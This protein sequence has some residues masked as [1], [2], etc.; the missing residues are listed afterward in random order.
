MP[1]AI[2]TAIKLSGYFYTTPLMYSRK[3][4]FAFCGSDF[5]CHSDLGPGGFPVQGH[6]SPTRELGMIFI[7]LK[8][9]LI[10]MKAHLQKQRQS[11]SPSSTLV[12]TS[13]NSAFS[14][15]SSNPFTRHPEILKFYFF[16][17]KRIKF[18]TML[19]FLQ[20]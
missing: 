15:A 16:F 9:S 17:F 10:K 8:N 5:R 3:E 18:Y 20:K 2:E 13:R 14:P 6:S 19:S 11:P 1:A 7:P 4:R 12:C